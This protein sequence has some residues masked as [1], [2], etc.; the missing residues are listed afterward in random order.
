MRGV[1]LCYNLNM[2]KNNWIDKQTYETRLIANAKTMECA[3]SEVQMVRFYKGK[4]SHYHK[5]KTEFFY[6]T[7]GK[8][9]VILD[10]TSIDLCAG[11]ELLVKPMATHSFINDSDT[12]LE[13]IMF[14]T[15]SQA[16]DTFKIDE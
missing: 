11:T 12:P 10:G 3:E 13:A 4:F 14:K 9:K 5:R 15:N 1:F 8:G 7:S 6:F 2:Q 16:D